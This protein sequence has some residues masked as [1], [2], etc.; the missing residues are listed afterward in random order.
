[1]KPQVRQ[2]YSNELVLDYF[3]EGSEGG[4]SERSQAVSRIREAYKQYLVL[5]DE[6]VQR[7]PSTAQALRHAFREANLSAVN[8]PQQYEQVYQEISATLSDLFMLK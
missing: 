4:A 2:T 6:V 1:M 5:H 3:S 7:D 8:N